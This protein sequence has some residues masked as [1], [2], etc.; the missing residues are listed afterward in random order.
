M[1]VKPSTPAGGDGF[2]VMTQSCLVCKRL[3]EPHGSQKTCSIECRRIRKRFQKRESSRRLR[4]TK[5]GREQRNKYERLRRKKSESKKKRQE[6]AKKWRMTE[7]GKKSSRDAVARYSSSDSG[8]K[9]IRER[10]RR[11]RED[12]ERQEKR[13]KYNRNRYKRLSH[14]RTPKVEQCLICGASYIRTRRQLTC[15]DRCSIAL[16]DLRRIEINNERRS[17][18]GRQRQAKYTRQW[19]MKISRLQ[20]QLDLLSI[21]GFLEQC[22]PQLND[23]QHPK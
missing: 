11:Y 16:K 18:I 3:F 22:L 23:D 4:S 20:Q 2:L 13:R 17:A 6:Y 10:E 15:S 8:R 19:R 1:V 14:L 21:K 7:K 12:S 9:K 5:E